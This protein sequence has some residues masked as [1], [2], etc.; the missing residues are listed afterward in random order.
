MAMH[1]QW[2]SIPS[3]AEIPT[4]IQNK[5]ICDLAFAVNKNLISKAKV[6]D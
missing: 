6:Y 5:Q 2:E 3:Y 1:K 4:P